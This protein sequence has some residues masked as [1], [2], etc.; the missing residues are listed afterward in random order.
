[1]ALFLEY[2]LRGLTLFK[3]SSEDITVSHGIENCPPNRGIIFRPKNEVGS[4]IESVDQ[5]IIG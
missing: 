3:L 5:F 4:S 1:M 2:V